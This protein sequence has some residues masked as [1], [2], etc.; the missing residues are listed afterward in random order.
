VTALARLWANDQLVRRLNLP[1]VLNLREVCLLGDSP[2]S[3]ATIPGRVAAQRNGRS[4][5]LFCSPLTTRMAFDPHQDD[6]RLES[7]RHL[8][9]GGVLADW[10]DLW[11]NAEARSILPEG[12][13]STS[14]PLRCCARAKKQALHDW[15]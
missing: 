6:P 9:Q 1:K 13:A 7:G 12:G 14:S 4:P 15:R 11:D 10:L 2:P 5:Y 8:G 3:S